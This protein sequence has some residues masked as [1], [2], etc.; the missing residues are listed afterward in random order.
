M[1]KSI[2]LILALVLAFAATACGG[3]APASDSSAPAPAEQSSEAPETSEDPAPAAE[4][5][6]VDFSTPVEVTFAS[7][8][9]KGSLSATMYEYFMEIATERSGGAITFNYMSDAVLGNEGESFQQLMDG[10][11]DG[12]G[13]GIATFTN[14]LTLLEVV[15]LPFLIDSYETEWAVIQ[16]PEFQELLRATE[17]AIGSV[18]IYGVVDVGIRHFGMVNKPINT[19]DDIKGVK[20]RTASSELLIEALQTVG[21]N[22]IVVG[23][24]EVYS[25]LQNGIVDGEDV[26]YMTAVSQNHHEVI[27]YFTEVGMYPYPTFL[28]FNKAFVD[29]LPEG[30]WD[31]MKSCMDEAMEIYFTESIVNADAGFRKTLEDNGVE[32]NTVSDIDAWREAMAP[33]YEK[34]S[35]DAD[36][37]VVDFIAAVE[38][39][40]A[41]S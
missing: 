28:A 41:A 9:K 23:Y 2:A 21:A 20:I 6:A 25:A 8:A 10:V 14:Y 15:Q 16:T 26:N 30:Y 32:V 38:K 34:Y 35:Q 5:G 36:Q 4:A 12:G 29:G 31:F 7:S 22:P 39:I 18:Y 11:I 27:K 40:K 24:T 19:I 33:L 3:S 1:K 17:E 13:G 37:R